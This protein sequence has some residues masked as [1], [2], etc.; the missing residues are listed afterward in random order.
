MPW[1]NKIE[2]GRYVLVKLTLDSFCNLGQF[3]GGKCK[4]IGGFWELWE[5]AFRM[6]DHHW[7]F[8]NISDTKPCASVIERN[9]LIYMVGHGVMIPCTPQR[10]SKERWRK[11]WKSPIRK[12]PLT[13]LANINR[14]IKRKNKSSS[15]Q[16]LEVAFMVLEQEVGVTVGKDLAKR[17]E[18]Y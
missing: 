7:F 17:G 8:Q 6:Y 1:L 2:N 9:T 5:L 18:E 11:N 3:L 12:L 16:S 14:E 13:P 10:K 4:I 15:R